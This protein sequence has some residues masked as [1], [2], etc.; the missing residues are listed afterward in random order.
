[1]W[2]WE[3]PGWPAVSYQSDAVTSIA[4]ENYY[5]FGKLS[6]V[7]QSLGDQQADLIQIEF[8]SD[9]VVSSYAIEGE[10]LQRDSVRQSMLARLDP[11]E[12]S[13]KKYE[14]LSA[15]FFDA[16]DGFDQAVNLNLLCR[17]HQAMFSQPS[18]LHPIKF[19]ELR[20]EGPMQ[21]VSG[22]LGRERVHYEA[23]P[24]S[25]LKTQLQMLFDY[26][27]TNKTDNIWVK[28]A[29]THLWF[30]VLHPF[31]DGNGRLGRLLSDFVISNGQEL[32]HRLFS[33]STA[34]L[35]ERKAYYAQLEK[36]SIGT[37]DITDWVAWYL[38]IC[39]RA[40]KLAFEKVN[41]V[42]VKSK[43][44]QQHAESALSSTQAKMINKIFDLVD[45][46][47]EGFKIG[48]Y[49]SITNLS[50]SSAAREINDLCARGIFRKLPST[51]NR[52]QRYKL[53]V[54]C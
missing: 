21:I 27:N 53:I 29:M 17:W 20:G 45:W 16:L 24:S 15:L 36:A 46:Q 37:L 48:Q 8:L 51:S 43:F 12:P 47:N 14:P 11:S 1:M 31:E 22:R 18:V 28:S 41:T 25:V 50:R 10:F 52:N 13:D 49:M 7:A 39:N 23:P 35:N 34:I 32:P 9:D 38:E 19:G 4:E 5:L 33:I 3:R 40:L 44:W 54:S 30:E 42:I 6:G 26:I 2:I